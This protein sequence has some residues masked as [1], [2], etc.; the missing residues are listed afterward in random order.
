MF[1]KKCGNEIKDGDEKCNKCGNTV[2]NK[3][4]KILLL[5][6]IAIIIIVT[7]I[8]AV[9]LLLK[10]NSNQSVETSTNAEKNKD[11]NENKNTE[12]NSS[13]A[14]ASANGTSSISFATLKA[15]DKSFD[16]TQK[17]LIDYFDN[18][19]FEFGI[20]LSQQYPQI[21]KGAKIKTNASIVKVLKSTDTEFEVVAVQEGDLL[22]ADI[23]TGEQ[24]ILSNGN[25]KNVDEYS[26]NELMII[27]GPQL[28]KRLTKG[29]AI[30]LYGRYNNVE[31][32][33]I[34]GKS[35]ILPVIDTINIIQL[36]NGNKDGNYR[37]NLD[38]A[39]TVAEYIFGKD[40]KIS[41]PAK[42]EDYNFEAYYTLDPF[43]KIT[44]DNQSNANFSTFNIYRTYGLIS[45]NEV[46]KN[47]VKNLF[48]GADFQHYIVSTY[49]KNL[50]H[51]YIDYFDKDLKKLWSREFD[52]NSSEVISPIDY[53]ST[54]LAIVID[55]DLHLINLETGEDIFE[56][57]LVGTKIKLHMMTDGIIL[58][59][60][61][62]KDTIMKVGLD[63]NI[64]FRTNG[65]TRMSDI[66]YAQTQIV[67]GKMVI[68]LE[69]TDKE[70]LPYDKHLVLNSDGSIETSTN[71]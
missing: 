52:Y 14:N 11:D 41:S 30:T 54:Q 38:T 50:K 4:W 62:N 21:F 66:G 8:F 6:V 44:L 31:T 2:K 37:F 55:N 19:Y 56:P 29:D 1:C 23:Y 53:T 40:I 67:N 20:A 7:T 3:K 39:K 36:S 43:Y 25:V 34:D 18:N 64:I 28:N 65:N 59:G 10:N 61:D 26:E 45:Y 13:S 22:A 9:T 70:G 49:D 15:D 27:K 33:E 48:I 69:G 17:T 42:G 16:K 63:G 24:T 51:V 68:Y 57:V 12:F 60:N 71:E 47:T 58:I 35:Y 32:F 46:S 5:L